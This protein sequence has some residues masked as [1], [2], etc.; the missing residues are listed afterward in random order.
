QELI[1]PTG[2]RN[3]L[4]TEGRGVF[5]CISPWN[6]P[7]AIFTGQV[8]A[9]LVAGNT[10]VAKPAEQ[11]PHVAARAIELM[12]QAGIP[13]DVVQLAIG[14][15]SV[16]GSALV[17]H[18]DTAGVVFTGSTDTAWIIQKS[19]AEKK[20]PIVPFIAETGGQNAMIVDSTA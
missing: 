18:A 8:V 12:H 11:T 3:L 20:G 10:V 13:K 4:R 5:V 17:A 15:G 2:E 14:R 9:A 7:L 6:F 16:V 1:G 19:L